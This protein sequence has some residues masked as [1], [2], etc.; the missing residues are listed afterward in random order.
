M[1]YL[2]IAYGLIAVVLI[3]YAFSIRQ[4]MSAAQRERAVLESK[5]Q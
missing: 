5:N 4:R 1:E 3:G 2:A